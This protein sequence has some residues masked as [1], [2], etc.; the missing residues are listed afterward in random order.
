LASSN[1]LQKQRHFVQNCIQDA[2]DQG[3]PIT[4]QRVS[5]RKCPPPKKWHKLSPGENGSHAMTTP[6]Y[7]QKKVKLA[8]ALAWASSLQ[9]TIFKPLEALPSQAQNDD[10]FS[11]ISPN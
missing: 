8:T 5:C 3:R 11:K 1:N 2:C 9:W 6:M 10:P 7:F 4:H